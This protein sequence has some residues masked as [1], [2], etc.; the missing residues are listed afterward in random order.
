MT[1]AF[2]TGSLILPEVELRQHIE[3]FRVELLKRERPQLETSLSRFHEAAWSLIEPK[4][5]RSNWHTELIDEHL[6]AVTLGQITRLIINQP[7]RTGKSTKVAVTWPAW[8]WTRK[9]GLR[10]FFSSYS[11]GLASMH[12][13]QR[14]GIL[15]SDWYREHW[16]HKFKIVGKRLQD[17]RNSA[18]GVMTATSVGGTGTGKG[19]D[20]L[21]ADDLLNVEQAYSQAERE[22]ANRYFDQTFSTRCDDWQSTAI[23]IIMQRLHENDLTGHVLKTALDHQ[24]TVLRLPLEAEGSETI[25]YPRSGRVHSRQPGESLFEERFPA[26][27]FANYKLRLGRYAYA[28]QMQ[29]RPAPLGGGILQRSWWRFYGTPQ[30]PKP[31]KFDAILQ[32]WDL[33]FKGKT[34]SDYVTGQ[35]WGKVQANLYLLAQVRTRMNFPACR[36]AMRDL[37]A[38]FPMTGEIAIENKANGPAIVD[39]LRNEISG[40]V[41]VEPDGDK[42]ARAHAITAHLESGNVYLPDESIAEGVWFTY[43]YIEVPG[44]SSVGKLVPVRTGLEDFL[45]EHDMFPNGAHDDQVDATTQ[46]LQRMTRGEPNMLGYLRSLVE[47]QKRQTDR[48]VSP[49]VTYGYGPNWQPPDPA[50]P[51]W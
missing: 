21:V 50:K 13:K 43:S 27:M 20:I 45:S 16:G 6:E 4:P 2:G 18:N 40:L 22:R 29:Q 25:T 23:V 3:Q 32:S 1:R 11:N 35:V 38:L 31:L 10:W 47:E 48:P 19:G 36:Q 5:W 33:A 28:G 30:N 51:N 26:Q 42:V 39:E 8:S 46:A 14:R 7:P 44:E 9:P 49:T 34:T 24:W 17:Y 37:K 15:E 12:G 41:L